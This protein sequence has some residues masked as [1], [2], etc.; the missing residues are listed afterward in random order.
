MENDLR[1]RHVG[2]LLGMKQSFAAS[3][4]SPPSVIRLQ[5]SKYVMKHIGDYT[6]VSCF[7]LVN[8]L[9]LVNYFNVC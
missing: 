7:T 8:Y 2:M 3:F 9:A 6:L 1:D 5:H 4:K